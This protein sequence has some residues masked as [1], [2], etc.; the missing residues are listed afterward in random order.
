VA[1]F[2]ITEDEAAEVIAQAYDLKDTL[3]S[4]YPGMSYEDGVTN[5]L[6]WALGQAEASPFDDG[7]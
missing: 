1:V 7:D 4:K 6:E 3:G 2:N 5:A